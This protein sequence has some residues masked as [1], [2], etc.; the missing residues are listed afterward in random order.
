M[1]KISNEEKKKRGTYKPSK[2]ANK[3]KEII[4]F[5]NLKPVSEIEPPE[6]AKNN[7][8]LLEAWRYTI[9]PLIATKK[10]FLPNVADLNHL[11]IL[12]REIYKL[13]TE[14]Q[15]TEVNSPNYKALN[16]MLIATMKEYSSLADRYFISPLAQERAKGFATQKEKPTNPLEDFL[17]S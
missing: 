5:D 2:D 10:I 4:V 8:Y 1:R 12:L 14:L 7:P 13:N 9:N 11:F 15:K 16:Q 6:E 17:N 3:G